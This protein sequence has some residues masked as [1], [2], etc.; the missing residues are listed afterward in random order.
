MNRR[1][2]Y[3]QH[4]SGPALAAFL[5][6]SAAWSL[7]EAQERMLLGQPSPET[8]RSWKEHRTGALSLDQV[9]R[10]SYVLRVFRL[11]QERDGATAWLLAPRHEP[12]FGGRRPL[13]VMCL[14]DIRGLRQVAQFLQADGEPAEGASRN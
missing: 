8:L 5:R 4:V 2:L 1:P 11:L 7:D 9:E 10:I 3:E 12:I 6:V 14:E 13:D